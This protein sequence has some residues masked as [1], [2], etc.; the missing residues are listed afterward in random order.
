M[1]CVTTR[2]KALVSNPGLPLL[3]HQVAHS[4]CQAALDTTVQ[5]FKQRKQ[6]Y[7][8]CVKNRGARKKPQKYVCQIQRDNIKIRR[9][10]VTKINPIILILWGMLNYNLVAYFHI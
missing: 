3:L 7:G 8:S 2:P 5:L 9:K 6:L 10:N 1:N 4:Y